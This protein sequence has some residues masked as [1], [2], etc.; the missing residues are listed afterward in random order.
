[1]SEDATLRGKRDFAD[2]IKLRTLRWEIIQVGP[3]DSQ[4]NYK[5]KEGGRRDGVR[6]GDVMT[7]A[8]VRVMQDHESSN[9]GG[10]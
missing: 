2:T 4:G 8:E 10:L 9:A 1:M 6:G 3:R 5:V 7:K